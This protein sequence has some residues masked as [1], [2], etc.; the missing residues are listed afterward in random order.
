MVDPETYAVIEKARPTLVVFIVASRSGSVI[1][2]GEQRSQRNIQLGRVTRRLLCAAVS[3]GLCCC[4]PI[5]C[6]AEAIRP[7][8]LD[9]TPHP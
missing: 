3:A 6:L 9:V 7:A 4:R 5:E 2:G 1:R 8:E